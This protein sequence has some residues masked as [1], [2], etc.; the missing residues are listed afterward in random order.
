MHWELLSELSPS[1]LNREGLSADIRRQFLKQSQ[2][3]SSGSMLP[4]EAHR[5]QEVHIYKFVV[6]ERMAQAA[7]KRKTCWPSMNQVQVRHCKDKVSKRQDT[8]DCDLLQLH[9]AKERLLEDATRIEYLAVRSWCTVSH[10]PYAYLD[11]YTTCWMTAEM[12]TGTQWRQKPRSGH[13]AH[14]G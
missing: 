4:R 14:D 3:P 1:K 6:E 13:A 2:L 8:I 7:K 10:C 12:K 11:Q 5:K 9:R